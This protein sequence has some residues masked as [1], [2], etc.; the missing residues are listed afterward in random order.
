MEDTQCTAV[1]GALAK[2]Y[3]IHIK[4]TN[5]TK[6]TAVQVSSK[7]RIFERLYLPIRPSFMQN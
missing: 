1:G 6:K 4:N 5:Q 7:F 2:S 3:I